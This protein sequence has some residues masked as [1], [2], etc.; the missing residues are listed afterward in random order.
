[1]RRKESHH[2]LLHIPVLCALLLLP[3]A[4][5]AGESE[6]SPQLEPVKVDTEVVRQCSCLQ[7]SQVVGTVEA[8]QRAAIAAKISG[9][10]VE[11]PVVLGS[12]VQQD[13][14]LVRIDAQEITARVLQAK[15]QLAKARRN[16]AREEK[17]LRQHASTPE[18]VK[19]MRDVLA[20]AEAGLREAKSMLAYTIIKA[21]FSGLITQKIANVGDLATPGM[22]L[23]KLENPDHL[24]VVTAIPESKAREVQLKTR[25]EVTIPAAAVRVSGTV[26]ELSPAVDP[27]SRTMPIKIDLSDIS[28]KTG[29][30]ARVTLPGTPDPAIMIPER[31]IVPFGQ[32]KK[33]F[34][35][36]KGKAWLRLVRTG[37]R[38][39]D[40]IE[41]LAGLDPG[42]RI[43]I[44]NNRLLVN[45]QP[46]ILAQTQSGS[47]K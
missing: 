27:H 41:I 17:L 20:I 19:A 5:L 13:D 3:A 35:V 46:L 25:L 14:L 42:E 22:P 9:V 38:R 32:L 31:A 37:R 47:G 18:T 34:V 40:S 11:L 26:T 43:V 16:L 7:R 28:L 45:G 8:A 2:I 23:L 15:A 36:E 24:Q 29:M 4:V 33:I 10:I 44:S 30:F 6:T 12:R 1:M 39:G 21:P